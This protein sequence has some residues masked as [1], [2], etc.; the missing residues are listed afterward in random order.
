MQANKQSNTMTFK[1]HNYVLIKG[2]AG[3]PARMWDV[4]LYTEKEYLAKKP[5]H[6]EKIRLLRESDNHLIQMHFA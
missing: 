3:A 1:G 2:N 6:R 5:E 4:S